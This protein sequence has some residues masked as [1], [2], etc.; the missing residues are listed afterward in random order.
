MIRRPPRSTLFPYTTLFRSRRETL[1]GQGCDR[2]TNHT[3]PCP[4]S[5]LRGR[6]SS[7]PRSLLCGPHGKSINIINPESWQSLPASYAGSGSPFVLRIG[8]CYTRRTV[9]SNHLPVHFLAID[10]ILDFGQKMGGEEG[11][12]LS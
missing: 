4:R 9:P 10:N 7:A 11:S 1:G 8:H 6:T 12:R 3:A 2:F 5:T